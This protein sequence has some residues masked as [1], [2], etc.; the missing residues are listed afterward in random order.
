M[1]AD[2]R[3]YH[4]DTKGFH[5]GPFAA[6][7]A[8]FRAYLPVVEKVMGCLMLTGVAFLTGFVSEASYWLLEA[9][10]ALGRIG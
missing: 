1:P 3:R 9:F 2:R 10:P 6:F 5:I 7:L 8:R 4:H